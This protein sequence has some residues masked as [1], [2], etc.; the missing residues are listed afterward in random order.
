MKKSDMS[1]VKELMPQFE[2]FGTRIVVPGML[3]KQALINAKHKKFNRAFTSF[4]DMELF[5]DLL[6]RN[7]PKDWLLDDA[8]D[9]SSDYDDNT[10]MMIPID[11]MQ[12]HYH[13]D[14]KKCERHARVMIQAPGIFKLTDIEEEAW[15]AFLQA[16]GK[17]TIVER[18]C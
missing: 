1:T 10:Y 5:L 13:R 6:Y 14:G 15:T 11:F 18:T 9:G 8:N 3:L 4:A 17:V 16:E 2:H 7:V 12:W